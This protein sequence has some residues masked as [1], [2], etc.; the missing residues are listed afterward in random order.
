MDHWTLRGSSNVVDRGEH[1]SLQVLLAA[2]VA[3]GSSKEPAR[4]VEVS[5]RGVRVYVSEI[6]QVRQKVVVRR[7]EAV[8]PGSVVWRSG[9]FAEIAF[10]SEIDERAFLRFRNERH[11]C[12]TCDQPVQ[13]NVSPPY[14]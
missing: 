2:E 12:P 7:G 6:F 11:R 8:I 13:L 3:D 5:A 14:L 4:I 10:D 1:R 9:R